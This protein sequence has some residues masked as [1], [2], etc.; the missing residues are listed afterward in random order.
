MQS[1]PPRDAMDWSI[2]TLAPPHA[3]NRYA[4]AIRRLPRRT[5][6]RPVDLFKSEF[7]LHSETELEIYYA[8]FEHLNRKARVVLI[9][10]TPGWT[11]MEI[12]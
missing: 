5:P 6:L 8:P 10:I 3:L 7:R 9:A 2:N 4:A 12:S 11:Q 1:G